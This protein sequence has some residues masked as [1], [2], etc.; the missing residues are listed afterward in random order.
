MA[1]VKLK[2]KKNSVKE[3]FVTG[4]GHT[5]TKDKFTEVDDT[6][7]DIAYYLNQY[8]EEFIFGHE[9]KQENKKSQK[10]SNSKNKKMDINEKDTSGKVSNEMSENEKEFSEEQNLESSQENSKKSKKKENS[11]TSE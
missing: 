2:L 1:K 8:G 7:M 10:Q 11:N 6:D 4:S 5:I 9:P 3:F